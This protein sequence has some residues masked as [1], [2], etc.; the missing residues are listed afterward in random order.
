[1]IK[2]AAP[3]NNKA[4]KLL[5]AERLV[6]KNLPKMLQD[7]KR[8]ISFGLTILVPFEFFQVFCQKFRH[9]FEPCNVIGVDFHQGLMRF[10]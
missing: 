8:V 4:D 10:Q 5:L 9:I 1:M 2:T 6:I 3:P 7:K